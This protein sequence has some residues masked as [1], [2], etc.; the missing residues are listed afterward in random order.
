MRGVFYF[1]TVDNGDHSVH[2][3]LIRSLFNLTDQ[4]ESAIRAIGALLKCLD[5]NR[6]S[7]L[8]LDGSG[9]VVSVK[10]LVIENVV[11]ID[12]TTFS[13]LQIFN[14]DWKPSASRFGSWNQKR[15][16]LSLFNV[17]NRCKSILGAKFLR[18]MFR[19]PPRDL[20]VIRQRQEVL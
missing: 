9:V 4:N 12:E 20:A 13:A 1:R 10:P 5:N 14:A 3:L 19:C 15:E 17:V 8:N 2:L 7:G 18:H 16:R 6:I 11:A